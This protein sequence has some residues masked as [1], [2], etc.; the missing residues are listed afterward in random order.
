M[1]RHAQQ[2]HIYSEKLELYI[3]RTTQY[4]RTAMP[5]F[6]ALEIEDARKWVS[7]G[8]DCA[9]R[10]G[11]FKE[12]AVLRFLEVMTAFGPHFGTLPEHR[13]PLMMLSDSDVIAK[14]PDSRAAILVLQ[15]VQL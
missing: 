9:R 5:H 14:W 8:V 7:A 12:D 3:E 11:F 4:L 15:G 6:A 13:L 1:I 10:C 2:N